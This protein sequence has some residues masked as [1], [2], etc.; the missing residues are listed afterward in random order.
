M[1]DGIERRFLASGGVSVT[2]PV[3]RA[4]ASIGT[5]SGYAAVFD[6]PSH[7]MGGWRES[8]APGAFAAALRSPTH[9]IL[10]LYDHEIGHLLGSTAAATLTLAED[11]V[12]LRF[13]IDLPNTSMGRDVLALV[14]RGDLAGAS[15]GFTLDAKRGTQWVKGRDGGAMQVIRAVKSLR[16]I[17]VVALPAYPAA[18]TMGAPARPET[19]ARQRCREAMEKMRRAVAMA[20]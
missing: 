14:Q 8:I 13:S 3:R 11:T 10:A 17:S 5:V 19:A 15:F 2:K 7:D 18:Y 6:T 12:G 20:G 16:E 9:P 4:G 1:S